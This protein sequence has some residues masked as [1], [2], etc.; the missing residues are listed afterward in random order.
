MATFKTPLIIGAGGSI[1]SVVVKALLAEPSLTVTALQRASSKSALPAGL[2]VVTIDDDYPAA[3]LEA[4]F[5]G[6]D[7]VINTMATAGVAEQHRFVDAAVAAGVRRYVPSEFGL[8]NN[9]AAA[10][11]LTSVFATK[12]AVQD[13]LRERVAA[14]GGTFEWTTFTP[15][16][17]LRWSMARGLVG[18]KVADGRFVF[19][20]GGDGNFSATSEENTA[21]AVARALTTERGVAL[22]RNRNVFLQDFRTSQREVCA[23][24]ERVLGRPLKHETLDG[25]AVIADLKAKV[26]AGDPV[27]H[28]QLIEPAFAMAGY[29]AWLEKE[30]DEILSEQLGLPK[31][32][33]D[34]VIK[35][36]LT[37]LKFI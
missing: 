13:Y 6:H 4:A 33:L 37:T 35:E 29:G 27:A 1:G 20:D 16:L 31:T 32:T 5:R 2:K 23:A 18:L 3:Q 9:N 26:A 34:E 25:N 24:V 22:S 14:S 12:G 10:R 11:A 28:L 30:G 36:A 17:W 8:N 19:W 7:V 21:L 15:G